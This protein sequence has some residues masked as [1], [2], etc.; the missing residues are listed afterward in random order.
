MVPDWSVQFH[1]LSECRKRVVPMTTAS[2]SRTP[3]IDAHQ[4]FWDPAAAHYPWMA[5]APAVLQR[6]FGP[7]DLEP[8]LAAADLDGSVLV[9]TRS[10]FG[11]SVEFLDIAGRHDFVL[12]VV[13]WVDLTSES[14]ADAIADLGAR[15]AGGKLVGIRHQV[16]DEPDPDWLLRADVQRGLAAVQDSELV[17]DLLVRPPNLASAVKTVHSFERTRFVVDHIAKPPIRTGETEPWASALR[18]LAAAPNVWCKISGLVTEANH[19]RWT[20]ADLAPYV[21]HVVDVFGIDRVLFGSDWPVC[22]VA[23]S[24]VDALDS[25]LEALGKV[26]DG[27]RAAFLGGTAADV[28]RLAGEMR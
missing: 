13:A 4:H 20:A 11:E 24:Y 5:G 22:L 19:E 6:A 8:L 14:C 23:A 26:S 16:E 28:Y 17:Y 25:T 9:Q 10:D 21:R 7:S 1:P 3:R 27:E 2:T 15:P 12:G 18:E